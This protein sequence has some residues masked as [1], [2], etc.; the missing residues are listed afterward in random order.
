MSRLWQGNGRSHEAASAL[1]SVTIAMNEMS[2][3]FTS[4]GPP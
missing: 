4:H 1:W 2:R 3:G